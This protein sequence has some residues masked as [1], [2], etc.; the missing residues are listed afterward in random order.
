MELPNLTK[1]I[2]DLVERSECPQESLLALTLSLAGL[3]RYTVQG[4]QKRHATDEEI[5][6]CM[7]LWDKSTRLANSLFAS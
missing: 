4:Q 1:D 2:A 5:K 6:E 3:I 7:R